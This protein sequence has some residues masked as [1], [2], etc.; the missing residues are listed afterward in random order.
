MKKRAL[1]LLLV[2]AALVFACSFGASAKDIA[3]GGYGD[4]EWALDDQGTLRI[5]GNGQ[6]GDAGS[7]YDIP[8]EPVRENIVKVVVEEGVTYVG[9]QAFVDCENLLLVSL[10]NTVT[11]LGQEVFNGCDDLILVLIPPSVTDMG[12]DPFRNIEDGPAIACRPESA[13]AA[14]ADENELFWLPYFDDV[15][16]AGDFYFLPVY[17]AFDYGVTTGTDAAH[18]SPY[19]ICT[20]AEVVTFLY[21]FMEMMA[22]E[23]VAKIINEFPDIPFSDVKAGAYYR[24]AVI[25]AAATGITTGTDATHFSPDKTCTRAEIVTFLYRFMEMMAPEYVAKI[26]NESPDIPF[27]DVK[28]DAYYHDAVIF[29]A[30]T[31]ITTGTDDTHFSPEMACSRG[32]VVTFLFRLD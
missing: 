4:V 29:A 1:L 31:G 23:F 5:F 10:P 8:W 24:D 28:A 15:M 26:I 13:A 19:K 30:A 9:S 17:W 3:M 6:M 12:I 25:F 32:Q 20:R 22:P 16:N 7:P 18:F 11:A 27:T 14:F 2:V 21:R